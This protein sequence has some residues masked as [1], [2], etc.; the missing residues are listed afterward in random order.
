MENKNISLAFGKKYK[1]SQ[2]DKELLKFSNI[3]KNIVSTSSVTGKPAKLF[4]DVLKRFLANKY[5]VSAL[6]IFILLLVTAFIAWAFSPFSTTKPISEVSS[7][8]VTELRPSFQGDVTFTLS[9]ELLQEINKINSSLIKGTP[10]NIGPETWVVTLNPYEVIDAIDKKDVSVYAFMGTDSYGRDIWLRT[11]VGTINAIAIAFA[12]ALIETIIGVIIGAFLGFNVGKRIDTLGLRL[13]EIFNAIPWVVLF[14]ILVGI[15]GTS[16]LSLILI[17]S[18]TGWTGAAS[19]TR[20]YTITVKDEE[21]VY[22]SQAIGASKMRLIFSHILPAISGKLANSFV[23]RI[24]AGIQAIAGIAFLG[25]IKEGVESAPNLGLLIT[26]SASLINQNPWALAF[27]SLILLV[28]SLSLRFV[29]LGFHDALD[30]K[31]VKK[32]AA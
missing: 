2:A 31:V 6:I 27:P 16:S 8:L 30:P 23:L 7:T 5:A 12:I 18:L 3:N 9:T 24:T 28:I 32:G 19:T 22:A 13:I 17:L 26:S 10:K 15:F 21:Y 14:I 1:F 25:F 11:W 4:V 20:S 29:A